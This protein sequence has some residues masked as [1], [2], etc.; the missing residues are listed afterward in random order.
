LPVVLALDCIDSYDREHHEIS[1]KYMRDKLATALTNREI[2]AAL[3]V[4]E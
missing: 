4:R 2:E 3:E 1:L